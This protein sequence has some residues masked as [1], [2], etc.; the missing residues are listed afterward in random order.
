MQGLLRLAGWG[1][2]ATAAL[3]FAVIAANSIGGRDRLSVAFAGINGTRAAEAAK[4]EAVQA[5]QLARLAA[6]EG[7][8]RRLIE[9][10]RSLA[11]DRERLLT[12]LSAL[13]RS[14]DDVTG[15]IQKQ[16][17]VTPPPA[18]PPPAAH[19]PAA[20]PEPPP[21]TAA[22]PPQTV[23]PAEPAT[24]PPPAEPPNK[25]AS[26]PPVAIPEL[27][28]IQSRQQA[29]VDVGGAKDFDGL[30]TL[31]SALTTNHF[32]LFEGLHPM[33]VVRENSKSRTADLRLVAGPLTDVEIA[34]R[35]CNTLAAAKRYCRLAPFEGQPLALHGEPP[36]RSTA[37]GRPT[38]VRAP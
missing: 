5:A 32:G 33:V 20:A 34:S 28:P 36:R 24:A 17:T 26:V 8:T 27:E 11:G 30:R 35:I 7:D 10:V 22:V 1:V 25:V 23:A 38:V 9:I 21:K 3:L 14:L 18:P 19:P 29:G 6:N 4:A 16:A 15:S 13:E 37:K 2:A 12:R 31:W